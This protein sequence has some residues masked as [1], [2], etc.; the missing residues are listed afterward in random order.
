MGIPTGIYS[1]PPEIGA[2]VLGHC[3]SPEL[4]IAASSS[5]VMRDFAALVVDGRA[6]TAMRGAMELMASADLGARRALQS[7]EELPLR[8]VVQRKLKETPLLDEATRIEALV[9]NG[10]PFEHTILFPETAISKLH[11]HWREPPSG[12][13]AIFSTSG[14]FQVGERVVALPFHVT[15]RKEFWMATV[16]EIKPNG[17]V[18]VAYGYKPEKGTYYDC[19]TLKAGYLGKVLLTTGEEVE[20]SSGDP[21]ISC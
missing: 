6:T 9:Q 2:L 14:A 11:A 4:R 20:K 15:H 17:A 12:V 21:G 7:L 19:T 5:G 1:L 3:S 18:R 16:R 8:S 10:K 13:S